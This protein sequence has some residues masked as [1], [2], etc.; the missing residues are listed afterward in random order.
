M[1]C[2]ESTEKLEHYQSEVEGRQTTLSL[3]EKLVGWEHFLLI[4]A[5][6]VLI[7]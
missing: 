5:F 3:Q 6:L 2:H 7:L 1:H 4:T